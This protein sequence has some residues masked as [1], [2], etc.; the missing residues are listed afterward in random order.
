MAGFYSARSS[1][2]PPLPW[3]TFAPPLSTGIGGL[4]LSG[5]HGYLTRQY[6]LAIDNLIEADVVLA[7]GRLVVASEIENADLLW[8][9]RG[10]GG[11]FGVVTSFLYRTNS[12]KMLYGGPIAFDMEQAADIMRWYREFQAISSPEFYIFL[13]LQAIPPTEPFPEEHWNKKICLLLVAHNGEDGQV[14][15]DKMRAALPKPLFD[16]CGPLT[17]TAL[18]TMFDPFYPKGLQWYWK[19][20]F[21]KTLPDEAIPIHIECAKKGNVFSAMHLYPIDK[22]VHRRRKD[23]TAWST[24]DAT[25]SMV[26]VGIDPDPEN[27]GTIKSWARDYWNAVHRFDLPGA[28]PNFMMDDEGDQRVRA[29]FGENYERLAELKRKFDPNNVFHVNHNIKP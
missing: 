20:D 25:W 15:V 5:G 14:Q 10:G 7:D 2:M 22:A 28:Y 13:G 26:I 9:L 19:G 29:S 18:Q 1:I 6:G 16:W 24:R 12:A 4:T 8:A 11:N 21:V 23:E 17:Y 3:P 27:A